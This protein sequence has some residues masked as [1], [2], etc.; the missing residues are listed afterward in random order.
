[1][2]NGNHFDK[3]Q[4][5]DY[6]LN[7]MAGNASMTRIWSSIKSAMRIESAI[8][9]LFSGSAQPEKHNDQV[10]AVPIRENAAAY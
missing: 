9:A 10:P 6:F 7:T 8:A 2:V 4:N 1:V 5:H 3:Y